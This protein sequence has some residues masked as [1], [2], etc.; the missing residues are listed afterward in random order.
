M[1]EIRITRELGDFAPKLV[2][3]FTGRQCLCLVCAA[4]PCYL[5]YTQLKKYLP[6]DVVGF[7]CVIPAGIAVAFGW[8][9]PYGMKMEAFLR[10]IFITSVLAPAIRRYKGPNRIQTLLS[11][12]EA[13]ELAAI[14]EE[15]GGTKKKKKK[16]TTKTQKYKRSPL[17]FR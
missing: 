12:V 15:Q 2:G 5:I 4:V 16:A 11:K 8:I 13:A 9:R 7:L 1:V 14:E 10:S 6:I 3:P 17:A